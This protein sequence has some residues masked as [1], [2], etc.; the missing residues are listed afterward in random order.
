MP[1]GYYFCDA[2]ALDKYPHPE[3]PLAPA[4]GGCGGGPS[5][6][7]TDSPFRPSVDRGKFFGSATSVQEFI[8]PMITGAPYPLKGL[9]CYGVN[10]F[11]S[12]PM[13]KR[14]QEALRNLNLYVAIDILP[15]EHVM[16]ADVTLYDTR[17]A[18]D[19]ATELGRRLGLGAYFP[20]ENI[21]EYLERR[22]SSIGSSLEALRQQGTMV[23]RG[24]PYFADYERL[25]R[26][27][28]DTPSGKIEL[29]IER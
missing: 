8:E 2:P 16:W 7:A 1:G 6:I 14:T 19:M 3:L 11:H 23:R 12:I 17:S 28:L 10:L 21:E 26:N 24:R 13:V 20:W 25:N 9:I 22:L 29:Y 4:A 15:M 18:F 27:P 5:E